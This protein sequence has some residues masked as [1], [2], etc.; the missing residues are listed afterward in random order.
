LE[1]G[2]C[3]ARRLRAPRAHHTATLLADVGL[4]GIIGGCTGFSL[5]DGCGPDSASGGSTNIVPSIEVINIDEL[6]DQSEA[7]AAQLTTPR[8][9]HTA[10]GVLSGGA[11]L[12]AIAGGLND[13]G[14]LRGVEFIQ[15]GGGS[16]VSA[17][18][19]ATALPEALVRHQ[20]VQLDDS[21]FVITGGQTLA[22]AGRLSATAPATA[23][24]VI[25]D[26]TDASAACA[27][28]PAMTTT[29][30]GHAMA[31]LR[32]RTLVVIGGVSG[33]GTTAEALRGSAWTPTTGTL[34][35]ARDRAAFTLL[36]GESGDAAFINQ[37][38]YS[39]GF[40]ADGGTKRTS[41]STDIYF[42]P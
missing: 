12:I 14:A 24:K 20:M 30:Y 37:V 11:G 36:G 7:A 6:S 34:A 3:A 25:C 8:A 10:V 16:L 35:V 39:G 15:V 19:V 18:A 5:A 27:N 22:P 33:S 2:R 29:R 40:T 32:D 41:S 38:F 28:G 4:V 42:G 1:I 17:G 13:T 9:M 21:R 31:Q 26:K 23:A